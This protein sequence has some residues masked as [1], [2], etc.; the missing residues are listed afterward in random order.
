[1]AKTKANLVRHGS[2]DSVWY[3]VEVVELSGW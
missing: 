1:M 3:C 2:L